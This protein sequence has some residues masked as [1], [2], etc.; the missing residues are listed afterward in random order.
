MFKTTIKHMPNTYN[1][2]RTQLLLDTKRW[3]ITGVAGFIGSNL[4][5][6]L[7]QLKQHVVG[8]DNF[9]TGHRHNL[10][11]VRKAVGEDRW[12]KFTFIEGDIRN[13]KDC[14]KAC[15]RIDIVLHHAALGSVSASIKDPILTNQSNIDGFVNMLVAAR[16][17][18]VARFIYAA[19][20][21]T[22]GNAPAL[23]QKENNT[24]KPLSP[25]ALTKHVN[26]LYADVFAGIYGLECIGLIY[27]NIF[28]KRQD[29]EGAYAAVIPRW[30]MEMSKGTAPRI[31]GDGRTSRDFCYIDD[32]I[33]ANLLAAMT[34]K[35]KAIN[36]VYNIAFGKRLTL[37]SLFK[38]IRSAVTVS[39]PEAG[40]IEPVYGPSRPGDVRHSQA[41]ISKARSLIGY[42]PGNAP[43]SGLDKTVKWFIENEKHAKLRHSRLPGILLRKDSGQAGM[44]GKGNPAAR[45]TQVKPVNSC[46][47]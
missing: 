20:A 43:I 28:G 13:I 9:S 8:L 42:N 16:D 34:K 30:I 45:R 32:V 44:T 7:L 18:G 11:D 23:P 31:N 38:L 5:E 1:K 21:A 24:G 6:A 12:N 35:K 40:K 26:E 15:K 27:F 10:D 2:V 47:N 39:K 17:A 29:P 46:Q 36:Q 14:R 41:D 4:L 19:S 37:N 22:Y 3:L 33:Q 25:Y